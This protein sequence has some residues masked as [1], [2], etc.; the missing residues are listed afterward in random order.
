[1]FETLGLIDVTLSVSDTLT[2]AGLTRFEYVRVAPAL[3]LVADGAGDGVFPHDTWATAIGSLNTA[4]TLA[5]HGTL[6]ILS[7][8]LHTVS[9]QLLLDKAVTLRGLTGKPE[10]VTVLRDS[11]FNNVQLNTFF[12]LNHAGARLESV[13]VHG[14]NLVRGN[15]VNINILGSGGTVTNCVIAMGN[16]GSWNGNPGGV[17]LGSPQALVTHCV[18][19]N[20]VQEFTNSEHLGGGVR[21]NAG[22]LENSLIADNRSGGADNGGQSNSG[23]VSVEGGTVLNCTIVGNSASG[24]ATNPTVFGGIRVSGGGLVLNSI[25]AGN[26]ITLPG[27]NPGGMAW[28]GTASLFQN[29]LMD[30]EPP[31]TGL[32]LTA[33][34]DDVFKAYAAQ[35]YRLKQGSPAVNA[36]PA[37]DPSTVAATDLDGLPRVY[38]SRID[39]G[40]YELQTSSA[41]LFMVR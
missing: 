4:L 1:V 19:T 32:W 33:N 23:G 2:T 34:A 39:L 37:T 36:G 7:N 8:G 12:V 41:T 14:N 11:G 13:F 30:V 17:R 20:N 26:S 6:I 38:G 10:D 9:A 3:I 27:N 40:C 31:V 28:G 22:R 5:D 35:N 15:S 25:I 18:I 21:M 24:H 16:S 29:C